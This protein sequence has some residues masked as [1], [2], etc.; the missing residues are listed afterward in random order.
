MWH[1]NDKRV[2]WTLLGFD[3]QAIVCFTQHI[4]M[5]TSFELNFQGGSFWSFERE[6]DFVRLS[7]IS[8]IFCWKKK[9]ISQVFR[10]FVAF[11]QLNF[12]SF[13]FQET[14]D[15]L[16]ISLEGFDVDFETVSGNFQCFNRIFHVF[17]KKIRFLSL[18]IFFKQFCNILLKL[19]INIPQKFPA[20][21]P[22][23]A[24]ECSPV[25]LA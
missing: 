24:P 2:C 22:L 4:S 10:K 11:K 12:D 6:R 5:S 25:M 14:F 18:L 16:K 15:N 13:Y 7:D 1:F 9:G 23:K 20:T 21:N 3:F 17:F 8:W 19:L